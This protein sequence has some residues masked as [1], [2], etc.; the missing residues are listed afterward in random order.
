MNISKLGA[1]HNKKLTVLVVEDDFCY[2]HSLQILLKSFGCEVMLAFDGEEGINVLN[3]NKEK[4]DLILLDIRMPIKSG[5]DFLVEANAENLLSDIPVYIQ[6]NE[7]IEKIDEAISI[8]ASGYIN[9]PYIKTEILK[10]IRGNN[11]ERLL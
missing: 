2:S 10:L 4:I 3:Q 5:I 9:K 11:N 8:G 1:N 7:S 6:S